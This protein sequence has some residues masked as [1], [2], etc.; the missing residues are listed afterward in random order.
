M[1]YYDNMAIETIFDHSPTKDEILELFDDD[2]SK[3]NYFTEIMDP[4]RENGIIYRLYFIRGDMK[5]ANKYL[6]RINSQSY[7]DDLES[8]DTI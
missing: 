5:K 2:I 7:K 1:L 6:N 8:I 3:D 4:D